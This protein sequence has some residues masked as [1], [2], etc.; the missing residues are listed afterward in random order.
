M[1]FYL[2]GESGTAGFFIPYLQ[3]LGFTLRSIQLP[4]IVLCVGNNG[5]VRRI[6]PTLYKSS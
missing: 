6:D 5:P 4:D 2:G 3:N 1:F